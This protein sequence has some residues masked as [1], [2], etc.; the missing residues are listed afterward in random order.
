MR[1][2]P[3]SCLVLATLLA[4]ISG[5]SAKSAAAVQP[6]STSFITASG[7]AIS[8]V[9]VGLRAPSSIFSGLMTDNYVQQHLLKAPKETRSCKS[10]SRLLGDFDLHGAAFVRTSDYGCQQQGTTCSG[11]Y[12]SPSVAYGCYAPG[13]GNE[14]PVKNATTDMDAPCDQGLAQVVQKC[15]SGESPDS[16]NCCISFVICTNDNSS[17]YVPGGGDE[18]SGGGGGGGDFGCVDWWGEIDR[19]PW[20]RIE[21]L[22]DVW[23]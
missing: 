19:G 10:S 11:S 21:C 9:F 8:S 14:C 1:L 22:A 4:M 23:Y 15:G 20:N 13:D 3:R 12:E 16:Y 6:L 18:G 7:E 2:I 17:C 5:A